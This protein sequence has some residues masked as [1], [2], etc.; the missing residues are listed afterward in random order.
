V[1]PWAA[2]SAGAILGE[3]SS[4]TSPRSTHFDSFAKGVLDTA[5]ITY[6]LSFFILVFFFL[7]LRLLRIQTVEGIKDE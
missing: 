1:L 5:D 3:R 7:T 6:C 2:Q 4:K